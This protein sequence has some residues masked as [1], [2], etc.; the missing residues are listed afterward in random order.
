MRCSYQQ[1]RCILLS[2]ELLLKQ[3]QSITLQ[4]NGFLLKRNQR[5]VTMW[6]NRVAAP[7]EWHSLRVSGFFSYFYFRLGKT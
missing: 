7:I 5:L 6:S 1:I 2:L 4:I 3:A